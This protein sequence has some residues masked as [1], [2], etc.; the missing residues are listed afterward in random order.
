MNDQYCD[1]FSDNLHLSL[2]VNDQQSRPQFD[3]WDEFIQ[4]SR[5][6]KEKVLSNKRNTENSKNW[7]PFDYQQFQDKVLPKR[8]NTEISNHWGVPNYQQFLNDPPKRRNF[9]NSTSIAIFQ[10]SIVSSVSRAN[11]CNTDNYQQSSDHGSERGD[12]VP[13]MSTMLFMSSGSRGNVNIS[14][15]FDHSS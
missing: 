3:R 4:Q 2:P 10:M 14:N 1:D 13:P 7:G 8:R 15:V 5:D 12:G 11:H 9:G 6:E